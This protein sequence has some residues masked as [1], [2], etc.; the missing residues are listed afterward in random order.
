VIWNAHFQHQLSILPQD[1]VVESRDVA[2]AIL[3][4]ETNGTIS[5]YQF[6]ST[7]SKT[8]QQGGQGGALNPNLAFNYDRNE[9]LATWHNT[10]AGKVYGHRINPYDKVTVTVDEFEIKPSLS[11]TP[12]SSFANKRNHFLLGFLKEG[13]GTTSILSIPDDPAPVVTSIS[14]PKGYAGDKI[15][16]TGSNFGKT[17]FLNAVWFGTT[18]AK[19]DTLFWDRTKLQ[20]TVP[21]GLTRDKVA[22]VVSFDG[23]KSNATV[24]F[25]NITVSG[26]ASVA[27]NVGHPGDV[28][29]ITG[30]NFPTDPNSFIVR[31]GPVTAALDDII[32]PVTSTQIKVKVPENAV[33]GANQVVSVVIQDVANDYVGFTVIRIPSIES[34]TP[35]DGQDIVSDRVLDI[36]GSNLSTHPNEVIGV[37]IGNKVVPGDNIESRSDTK[38]SIKVPRGIDGSQRVYIETLDGEAESPEEYRFYVGADIKSVWLD[39][40]EVVTELG[41][42]KPY[43]ESDFPVE[44]E[45]FNRATVKE[46]K[47][48]SKGISSDEE[49]Q[50]QNKS[51]TYENS[52]LLKLSEADL[53]EDPLGLQFY[54]EVIDSSAVVKRTDTLRIFRDYINSGTTAS[55]P[56]LRFGGNVEDYTIISIPY[57]LSPS[58]LS[59]NNKISTVFRSMFEEYGYDASKWRILHYKN[60]GGA[61]AGYVEYL[62]GLDDID[63]GKGYWFISRYENEIIFDIGKTLHTNYGPFEITLK[64][65]WNQ[66]GNPYDFNISWE[67]IMT[68]S[69]NPDGVEPLK[70]FVNGSFQPATSI[71]RY[72]GGFV[73]SATEATL[74][75][76]FAQNPSI[77]G[78]RK[79]E[80]SRQFSSKLDEK[81]WRIALD[82]SAGEL[83]NLVSSFGMHPQANED[84]DERD[85]HKLPAFI[86]SL[87]LSF[88]HSLSTSIVGTDDHFTWD[89]ELINTTDSKEVTITW[90]NTSF[91][92]ND[93]ELYLQDN[94]KQRLIDMRKENHYTFTY[95]EGYSFKIHF[96]DKSYI[97]EIAKPSSVVLSDAYPNPMHSSTRIPFT[98]VKDNTHVR[99]GI[100]TLQGEEI[101][102]LVNTNF[103]T[104]FYEFEWDG[105]GPTGGEMSSGVVIYRLQSSEAATSVKSYF[106]KLVITP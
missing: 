106:K 11:E 84:V 28:I 38:I 2:A 19:V 75:I 65:G 31:F 20:V 12:A 60:D 101:Q 41:A 56:D 54:F 5:K 73:F 9:F 70:T 27:P 82:L 51:F 18:K 22:V 1:G 91:G 10:N 6:P 93:R 34:A 16:I 100:Y 103:D 23:Q 14:K 97:E 62:E 47:F 104:G 37:R 96:G 72:R 78:G 74:K 15:I 83:K 50:S 59:P 44:V 40:D 94:A 32:V 26:I 8:Q 80:E 24:M 90:E 79:N 52:S 17:P 4:F 21:S 64:A 88:P 68:E 76:P 69:G 87:D 46:L 102:T 95:H 25:E 85:E 71:D 99:L 7:I 92:D 48:W 55:I 43:V 89:L 66:I 77:N 33:R 49:W 61:S 13:A 36:N 98:V 35:N 57:D 45:V 30:T 39:N 29:T 67:E 3:S 105:K 63:P 42:S 53:T 81:E 86:Q 58:D